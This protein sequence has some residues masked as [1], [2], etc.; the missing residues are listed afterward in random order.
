MEYTSHRFTKIKF[1]VSDTGTPTLQFDYLAKHKEEGSWKNSTDKFKDQIPHHHFRSL[2]D[3]LLD[4][5]MENM[6]VILGDI[7]WG[8]HSARCTTIQ[9]TFEDGI[10]ETVRYF[11]TVRTEYDKAVAIPTPPMPPAMENDEIDTLQDLC[12]EATQFLQGKRDQQK[13]SFDDV[14]RLTSERLN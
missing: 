1:K 14:D 13:M 5:W 11:V 12:A 8:F 6:E 4:Y 10:I 3:R 7:D 9:L 2:W